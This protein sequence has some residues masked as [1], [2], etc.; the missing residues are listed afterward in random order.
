MTTTTTTLN[1]L[2]GRTW[3]KNGNEIGYINLS[4]SSS[5]EEPHHE[6]W[7]SVYVVGYVATDYVDQTPR[8]QTKRKI[9]LPCPAPP[10]LHI[11]AIYNVGGWQQTANNNRNWGVHKLWASLF[12]GYRL[13]LHAPHLSQKLSPPSRLCTKTPVNPRLLFGK[14]PASS[15]GW[16]EWETFSVVKS[17]KLGLIKLRTLL[18][19]AVAI[20]EL[21]EIVI[22][23]WPINYYQIVVAFSACIFLKL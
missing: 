23:H 1:L 20:L 4:I 17:V 11:L 10:Q 3:N 8:R 19:S 2:V 16:V 5:K 13:L 22:E 7:L 12:S 15:E 6:L 18:D 9:N 14:Q 21:M